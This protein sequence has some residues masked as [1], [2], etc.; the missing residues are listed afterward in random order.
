MQELQESQIE[1]A[2]E[3]ATEEPIRDYVP[4]NEIIPTEQLKLATTAMEELV[5]IYNTISQEGVSSHDLADVKNITDRLANAGMVLPKRYSL[6]SYSKLVTSQRTSLNLE[7]STE[8]IL[9]TIL[10]TLK[11]WI[12][13]LVE[14]VTKTIRWFKSV[15][16]A[17]ILALKRIE[18][19]NNAAIRAKSSYEEMLKLNDRPS[20][21]ALEQIEKITKENLKDPALRRNRATLTAFGE[22]QSVLDTKTQYLFLEKHTRD[23]LEL[24]GRL[25]ALVENHDATDVIKSLQLFYVNTNDNIDNTYGQLEDL[26]KDDV[27]ENYFIKHKNLGLKFYEHFEKRILTREYFSYRTIYDDYVKCADLLSKFRQVTSRL[28]PD[29]FDPDEFDKVQDLLKTISNQVNMINKSVDLFNQLKSSYIK[30]SILHT[31]QFLQMA[32]ILMNDY[33]PLTDQQEANLR[34]VVKTLEKIFKDLGL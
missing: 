21:E 27:E 16:K 4:E 13:W 2:N 12:Q 20:S 26:F 31:N 32:K 5:G 34:R 10:V 19:Y 11:K 7:I 17:D 3:I 22:P 18:H 23:L 33:N 9:N 29:K 15:T 14:S 25:I 8:S 1:L 28:N 6:E 30:V 24:T